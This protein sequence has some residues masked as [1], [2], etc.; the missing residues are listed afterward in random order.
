MFV[1]YI[2][3]GVFRFCGVCTPL[4]PSITQL[5]SFQ[6]KYN[7]GRK[8]G[9]N[10]PRDRKAHMVNM[11]LYTYL[12]DAAWR[13]SMYLGYVWVRSSMCSM[14]MPCLRDVNVL[15]LLRYAPLAASDV[16]MA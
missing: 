15:P 1:C 13:D 6:H 3:L 16:Y 5:S 9:R 14:H 8:G 11:V 7:M 12:Y 2:K 4:R 10:R